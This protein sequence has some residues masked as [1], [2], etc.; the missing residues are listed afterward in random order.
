MCS[1]FSVILS[2]SYG[3][4]YHMYKVDG[5]FSLCSVAPVLSL[6]CEWANITNCLI[7]APATDRGGGEVCGV[8]RPGGFPTLHRWPGHHFQYVPWVWSHRRVLPCGREKSGVPPTNRWVLL[9]ILGLKKYVRP[10]YIGSIKSG[11]LLMHFEEGK[12]FLM[13]LYNIMFKLFNKNLWIL[14]IIKSKINICS[15]VTYFQF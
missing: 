5:F 4:L 14:Y 15:K 11:I 7:V 6:F 1:G 12:P 2:H 13:I 3:T 9:G 10:N 8:F